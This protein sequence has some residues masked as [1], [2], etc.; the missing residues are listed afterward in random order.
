MSCCSDDY[1]P[2]EVE[3]TGAGV[4]FEGDYNDWLSSCESAWDGKAAGCELS[5]DVCEWYVCLW[6]ESLSV[7]PKT[8]KGPFVT[9]IATSDVEGD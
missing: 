1:G 9:A 3:A 7:V 2:V 8:S 4:L 5:L 6:V